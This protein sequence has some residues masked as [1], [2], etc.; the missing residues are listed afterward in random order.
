MSGYFAAAKA[1]RQ[2]LQIHA[3]MPFELN[4]R[5]SPNAAPPGAAPWPRCPT[6]GT[7]D[8]S[9]Q[10]RTGERAVAQAKHCL[11]R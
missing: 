8:L 5:P 10:R 11:F 9:K 3:G 2:R 6:L 1:K 7:G 4:S